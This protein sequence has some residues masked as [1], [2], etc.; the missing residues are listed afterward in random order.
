VDL[1]GATQFNQKILD[2]PAL[3][4]FS[5]RDCRLACADFPEYAQWLFPG[6]LLQLIMRVG[7]LTRR[8]RITLLEMAPC[9]IAAP[10]CWPA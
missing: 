9:S 2:G 10:D 7:F 8:A 5:V 1:F 6:T 4:L 3:Q